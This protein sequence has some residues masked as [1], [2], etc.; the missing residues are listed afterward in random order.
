MYYLRKIQDAFWLPNMQINLAQ[1]NPAEAQRNTGE[2]FNEY[3]IIH[4]NEPKMLLLSLC[5]QKSPIIGWYDSI[6]WLYIAKLN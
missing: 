2:N 1:I 5:I 3:H 4:I 6:I